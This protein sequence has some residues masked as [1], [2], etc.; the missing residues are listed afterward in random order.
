MKSSRTHRLLVAFDQLLNVILCD[1][2]EDETMSSNVY[3]MEQEGRRAGVLRKYIDM[4]FFWQSD[5]CHKSFEAEQRRHGQPPSMRIVGKSSKY[6]A[7]GEKGEHKMGEP[8][9]ADE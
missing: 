9:E 5:H 3:R 7:H 8:K 4:L 6:H 1:G 2:W